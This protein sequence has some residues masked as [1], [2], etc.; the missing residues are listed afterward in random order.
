[1]NRALLLLVLLFPGWLAA[2]E[3]PFTVRA[4]TRYSVSGMVGVEQV[5]SLKY[6]QLRLIQEFK[7]QK[8]GLGVDLD[9]LFDQD[10]HLRKKD[11]DHLDD[12]L[13]KIYYLKFG[14]KGDPFYF[15]L[16]GFPSLSMGY[17]LMM[18]NYSNMLLYPGLRNN[19]L[20][21]GGSPHWPGDPSFE[22]FTSDIKK[23]QILSFTGRFH[24]LPDTTRQ[25][26]Q[27]L[28][29]GFSLAADTNQYGNL[30]YI[31]GDSLYNE[32]GKPRRDGVG[33]FGLAYTLPVF[34][35][36]KLT[37]GT[38]SEFAHILGNGSGV[39]LPGIYTD[40][41]FLILSLEYRLY[42]G[43]FTPAFFDY[44]YEEERAFQPDPNVLVFRTKEDL[45][46]TTKAAHGFNGSIQ[47]L[48]SHKKFKASFAWQNLI[49]RNLKTGKSIWLKLWVDTQY[50]RL[51]NFSLS[52]SKTNTE[53]MAI[54]KLY[55]P[56]ASIQA[57]VTFHASKRWYLI[58]KYSERYKDRNGDGVTNWVKE[59]KRSAGIGVKYVY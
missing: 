56:N 46:K 30:K 43:Q 45:L 7:I 10:Y 19:G 33:M 32:I 23:N 58:G 3:L 55:E 17:G 26:L 59:T 35:K 51:E 20:I 42:G 57:A 27:D 44:S 6:Y 14:R 12:V 2:Q 8:F 48:F 50:K 29:L 39:I 47:G 41:D 34:K 1:M 40:L 22:L 28:V 11:W 18:Y 53:S 31:V 54:H 15:H 5:D 24:P 49:G 16:G 38:Y 37:L 13:D 9:F 36:E 4:K 25:I 52:Y 21:L